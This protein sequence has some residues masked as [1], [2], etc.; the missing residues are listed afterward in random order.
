MRGLPGALALVVRGTRSV[1][2]SPE[3]MAEGSR[4][5]AT[6]PDNAVARVAV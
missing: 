5:E 1:P 4:T 3:L 6:R 2:A